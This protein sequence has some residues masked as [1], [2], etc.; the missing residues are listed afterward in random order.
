[1]SGI[2]Q[3]GV[4]AGFF[5]LGVDEDGEGKSSEKVGS[6]WVGS[7]G[8]ETE[9]RCRLEA[10]REDDPDCKKVPIGIAQLNRL[11]CS[12]SAGEVTVPSAKT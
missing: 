9:G 10:D 12:H 11:I 3:S 7:G 1:M 4:G 6:L 8:G 2:Y 5:S